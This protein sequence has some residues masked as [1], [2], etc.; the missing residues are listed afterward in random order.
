VQLGQGRCLSVAGKRIDETIAAEM[1]RAV[2]P[3][4][5]EAAEE[6][7]RMLKDE[8]QDRRRIAELELH[9]A[10]LEK[11]WETAL[12]RVER[13]R[14]RLDRMQMP[15]ADD[16]RPDFTGLADDLLAAWKAPRTTMRTRGCQP[17]HQ[18]SSPTVA[19]RIDT[20]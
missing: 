11:A 6:A 20:S 7:E 16:V 18:P 17:R 15:D 12:Q 14:E 5:I 19:I 4:A 1:L 10:Q 9:A 3:M 8:D 2:A 13:C